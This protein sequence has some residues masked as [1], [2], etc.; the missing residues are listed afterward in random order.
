M[1]SSLFKITWYVKDLNINKTYTGKV[2]GSDL[3]VDSENV[4]FFGW[5]RFLSV[6]W[7]YC[8]LS[9]SQNHM[10]VLFTIFIVHYFS[11]VMYAC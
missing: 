8:T 1:Y 4:A 6:T 10:F 5:I 11:V 9:T 3:D 2:L 7:F